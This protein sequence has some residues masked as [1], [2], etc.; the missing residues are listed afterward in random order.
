MR[1]DLKTDSHNATRVMIIHLPGLQTWAN[2]HS[3]M[4]I[5]DD[6]D[7]EDRDKR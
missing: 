1:Y 3:P 2:N 5:E 6:D 7:D 4:M